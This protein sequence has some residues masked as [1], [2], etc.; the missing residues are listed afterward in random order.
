M[1][2]KET[3]ISS[4]ENDQVKSISL[5]LSDIIILGNTLP[6]KKLLVNL[7]ILSR[8]GIALVFGSHLQRVSRKL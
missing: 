2:H 4:F 5:A 8:N 7:S 3:A 6:E 1:W